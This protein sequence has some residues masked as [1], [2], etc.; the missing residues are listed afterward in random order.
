MD[1]SGWLN[2]A[3][4]AF[5][6]TVVLLFSSVVGAQIP[7]KVTFTRDVAPILQQKCE[8]CHRPGQMAPMSLVYIRG[9]TPVGASNSTEGRGS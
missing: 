5:V 7:E 6:A 1:H 2:R 8:V 4:V 9:S 3:D